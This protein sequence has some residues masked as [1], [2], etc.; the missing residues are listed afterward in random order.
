MSVRSSLLSAL[1]FGSQHIPHRNA[2]EIKDAMLDTGVE[3]E[4]EVW[5][6]TFPPILA[7]INRIWNVSLH[8]HEHGAVIH[9]LHIAT[10]G[11]YLG[12]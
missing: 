2:D 12:R 11:R 3:S 7:P 4:L 1:G 8:T 9:Q 10:D 5:Q 6:L